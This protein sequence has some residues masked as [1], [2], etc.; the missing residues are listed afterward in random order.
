MYWASNGTV[1]VMRRTSISETNGSKP[2]YRVKDR[3]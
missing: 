1:K 3:P 2:T